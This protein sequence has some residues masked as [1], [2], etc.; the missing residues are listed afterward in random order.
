MKGNIMTI[1]RIPLEFPQCLRYN[2]KDH[3]LDEG[4]V[5]VED[6]MI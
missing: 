4:K 6:M 3:V 1:K 5:I 2:Q